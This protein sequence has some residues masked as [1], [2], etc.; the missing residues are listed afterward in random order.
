M[1]SYLN[2]KNKARN[3]SLFIIK[4]KPCFFRAFNQLKTMKL[5]KDEIL[6]CELYMNGTATY[7]GN[8]SKCYR[9]VFHDDSK[10]VSVKAHKLLK[11]PHIQEY[12]KELEELSIE[13][14]QAMKRYLT[15]NLMSI[16]NEASTAHYMDRF[17][18]KLS[19]APL[20]SVAVSASKALMEMYP[21][22]EAQRVNLET[23]NGGIVFNVVVPEQKKDEQKEND[24]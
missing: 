16:I 14:A 17:G 1:T 10:T 18:T 8:A 5:T 12:L 13:E 7:A 2:I 19:P 3:L 15:A 20:R 23:E 11:E 6:F 4:T 22:K 21:V 9:E 24:E